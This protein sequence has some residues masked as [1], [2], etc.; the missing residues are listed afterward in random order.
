MSRLALFDL[1]NTL[2]DRDAGYR[3]WAERFLAAQG[4]DGA[5]QAGE[6]A[7]LVEMD[8]EG[9]APR[10]ALFAAIRDRYRLADDVDALHQAY[11]DALESLYRPDAEV[12]GALGALQAAGWRTV[13]ITNGPPSQEVK[14]RA[15]G[16]H[17][18]L[19]SWCISGVEGVLK[20]DRAIFEA[21][22]SRCG[23]PLEGW[24]VGD[25]AHADIGGGVGAG[26]RTIWLS[27][28]RTWD[29][30]DY[31]PDVVSE[32]VVEAARTILHDGVTD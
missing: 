13:V 16:L 4:V 9:L 8:G 25:N 21:A 27:R 18:V 31:A 14:I 10:P 6:L 5:E 32:T 19:D 3:L 17:D 29:V 26:L 20:P 23:V 1:D 22:A 30:A 24:M 2:I 7:W 11:S 12:V 15:A 28:G